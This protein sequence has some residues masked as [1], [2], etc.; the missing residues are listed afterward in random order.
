MSTVKNF[1]LTPAEIQK[2]APSVFAEK[3]WDGVSSRYRFIPTI[4]FVESLMSEDRY[5]RA[6]RNT[7][8]EVKPITEDIKLNNALWTLAG[9]MKNL[10]KAA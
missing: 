3:P 8:R 2:Y 7:T 5:L 9:G 6:R 4:A 1:P 10:K